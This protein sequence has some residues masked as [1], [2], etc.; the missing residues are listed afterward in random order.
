MRHAALAFFA[1]YF[2]I[3]LPASAGSIPVLNFGFEDLALG[4]PGDF[5]LNDI[6]DWTV[7]GQ[8]S[9]FWPDTAEYPGGAPQGL[10]VA[11]IGDSFGGGVVS[12]VLSATLQAD[13][14]YTL[15]VDVGARLDF[16]FLGYSVALL[17]NGV[18][19]ASDSS[20]TPNP[21][22]F[23]TDTILYNSGSNPGQLGQNLEI[24]LS[25]PISGQVDFDNVILN[26][27]PT[28]AV[29][30]PGSLWLMVIGSTGLLSLCRQRFAGR[31]C[32]PFL[33]A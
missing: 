1:L 8:T 24:V 16:P 29:P 26:A 30:E 5:V 21:G 9:T 10:N 11:A 19:L 22:T 25:G 31:R 2:S 20:L 33:S 4:A 7:S 13:M 12:Q 17:A 6:T 15:T 32:P 3:A 23:L 14:T 18:T 27:S 28:I